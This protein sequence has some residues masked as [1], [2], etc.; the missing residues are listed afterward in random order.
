MN[1]I[2]RYIVPFFSPMSNTQIA[3]RTSSARRHFPSRV[4]RVVK[5]TAPVESPV[6]RIQPA[7]ALLVLARILEWTGMNGDAGAGTYHRRK[8]TGSG[9]ADR[10]H[11]DPQNANT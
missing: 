8:P 2:W 5:R 1:L 11:W 6:T 7:K 4:G 9:P 10:I 3:Q